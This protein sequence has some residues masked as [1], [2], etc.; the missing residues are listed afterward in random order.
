MIHA[1]CEKST[2]FD[3]RL[4]TESRLG[5]PPDPHREP[6]APRVSRIRAHLPIIPPQT[7]KHN[8]FAILAAD[9]NQGATRP[10]FGR[11][12]AILPGELLENVA[13]PDSRHLAAP[14]RIESHH[15]L[16]HEAG[17]AT[18]SLDGI[19]RYLQTVLPEGF[20]PDE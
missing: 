15:V 10:L 9:R 11:S 17:A 8:Q 1:A 13:P 5:M 19:R 7:V 2:V 14:S 3:R 16:V 12:V 20:A 6:S 4:S 18:A